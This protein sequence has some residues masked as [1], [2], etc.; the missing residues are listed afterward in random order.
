MLWGRHQE[1]EE[2]EEGRYELRPGNKVNKVVPNMAT[3][4]QVHTT[5]ME[6]IRRDYKRHKG[7]VDQGRSLFKYQQDKSK[8]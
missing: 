1:E 5:M 7:K 8:D 3:I 4:S 6:S 2:D